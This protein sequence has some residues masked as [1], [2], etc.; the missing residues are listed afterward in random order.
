MTI[1]DAPAAPGERLTMDAL[2]DVDDLVVRF[3]TPNGD[4]TAVRGVSFSVAA[5]ERLGIVGESGSGKSV[6]AQAVMRLLG[7]AATVESGAVRFEGR[8]V[9]AFPRDEL[10]RWRGAQAAMVFQDPLSSLNPLVRIGRQVTETL[11]EHLGMDRGAAAVRA[12][13]LLAEVGIPDAAARLRDYPMTFSGGMR[14]R[15][16]VAI[17]VSCSPRLLI[18]DEPT[19]ALDVTVQAQ[20]LDLMDRMTAELGTA[21]ILIS[22][23]LGVVSTFCDRV[24]VMYG[25]RVVES[26]TTEEIV[27][28]PR[29]PYTRALLGSIPAMTGPLPR[30]LPS[31]PGSPPQAGARPPGCSFASRCPLAED[32]CH[33]IEPRMEDGVACHVAT[34]AGERP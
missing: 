19:T 18:A 2:L 10:R 15:V 24:L 30:R 8:D 29:H 5:G 20:V 17:A 6:T 21:V 25:G 1:P 27:G 16:A 7:P 31:I 23:D 32:V 14:Q 9:L 3:A 22:H 28:A 4:H 11:R 13:E 34:G 33:E 26:G 12:A